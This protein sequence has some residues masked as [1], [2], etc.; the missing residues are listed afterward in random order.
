M[1]FYLQAC[2]E[3]AGDDAAFTAK[4]LVTIARAKGMSQLARAGSE[5]LLKILAELIN[6]FDE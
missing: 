3:E 5:T 6:W 1:A 2:M 4:A